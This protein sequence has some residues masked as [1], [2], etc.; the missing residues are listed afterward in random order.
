MHC[1]PMSV[2]RAQCSA[3]V[4]PQPRTH[5]THRT[6]PPSSPSLASR[7]LTRL[8]SPASWAFLLAGTQGSALGTRVH[9]SAVQHGSHRWRLNPRLR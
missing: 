2:D 8:L 5:L 4:S 3:P 9:T 1:V 6:C 7:S